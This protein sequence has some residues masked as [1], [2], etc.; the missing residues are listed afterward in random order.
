MVALPLV[1]ALSF[2]L[3]TCCS[4]SRSARRD[5]LDLADTDFDYLAAE[6]ETM[7]VLFYAPW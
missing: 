6:H 1:P 3:L 5:V 2:F 7:L 4:V